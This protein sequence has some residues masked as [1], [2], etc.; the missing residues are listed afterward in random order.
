MVDIE[1]RGGGFAEVH[2][3]VSGSNQDKAWTSGNIDAGMVTVG[4]S[5]GLIK[6][7]P[8]CQELVKTIVNDAEQL[9]TNRLAST[10][11]NAEVVQTTGA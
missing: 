6:N 11:V 1:A 3:L 4:M 5:G 7:I 10:I 9:I 8:T 2:P